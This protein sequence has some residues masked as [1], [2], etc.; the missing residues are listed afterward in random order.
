MC[1]INSMTTHEIVLGVIILIFALIAVY[2]LRSRN[3]FKK[4]AKEYYDN[5]QKRQDLAFRM[6][7]NQERGDI[8]ELIGTFKSFLDYDQILTLSST[9][10]QGSMDL[11]GI[12]KELDKENPKHLIDGSIDFIEIKTKHLDKSPDSLSPSERHIKQ[13]V[14]AKKVRY[15]IKDVTIPEGVTVK[16]R[17]FKKSEL[18]TESKEDIDKTVD[19]LSAK[20]DEALDKEKKGPKDP[21]DWMDL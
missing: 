14:D 17:K 2:T 1:V 4:L 8:Y 12:R 10:Q 15:I 3:K 5:W 9:S 16:D 6:G 7:G 20:V 18:K 19:E 11:L 21:D 13:L